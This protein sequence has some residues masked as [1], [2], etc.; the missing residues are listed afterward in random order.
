MLDAG[1]ELGLGLD[2]AAS[3]GPIDMFAEMRAAIEVSHAR[4]EPVTP[5]EVWKMATNAC[6]LPLLNTP[7]AWDIVIGSTVPLI[8][9]HVEQPRDT[10][11]LIER[12]SP[13]LIRW[14]EA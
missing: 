13:Q 2:S 6:S 5:E 1:I 3:S 10:Y 7:E 4:G 8:E 11:D 14:V 9:V 12:G